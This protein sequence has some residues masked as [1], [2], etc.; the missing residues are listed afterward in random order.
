MRRKYTKELQILK[1]PIGHK[2]TLPVMTGNIKE[3]KP[4][5]QPTPRRATLES[6]IKIMQAIREIGQRVQKDACCISLG[7]LR[8]SENY[9]RNIPKSTLQSGHTSTRK[10]V[11]T[12]TKSAV[13]P[14][15]L[16]A[17]RK[18]LTPWNPMMRLPQGKGREK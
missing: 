1:I 13:R 16:T 15:I 11:P 6:A 9:L 7:T 3:E 2:P 18:R 10:H 17:K 14:S 4:P 12:E 5:R 8:Q